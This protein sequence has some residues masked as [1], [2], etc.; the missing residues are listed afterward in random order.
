M[1]QTKTTTK[2][3]TKKLTGKAREE[4]S[5][6]LFKNIREYNLLGFRIGDGLRNMFDTLVTAISKKKASV[7]PVYT[8][9]VH[10]GTSLVVFNF[11]ISVA[12]KKTVPYTVDV[13]VNKEKPGKTGLHLTITPKAPK[14]PTVKD[15][16]FSEKGVKDF[17]KAVLKDAK[18]AK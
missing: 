18:A 10:G 16:Q 1:A 3:T 5:K 8:Y 4:Q 13:V 12:G 6:E 15:F 7:N 2:K 17:V 11:G 14:L 9:T